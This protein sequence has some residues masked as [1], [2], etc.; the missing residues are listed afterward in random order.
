[1]NIHFIG[2]YEGHGLIKKIHKLHGTIF[3]DFF[4][5]ARR[6]RY[7][8]MCGLYAHKNQNY[9]PTYETIFSSKRPLPNDSTKKSL[10][11]LYVGLN[12]INTCLKVLANNFHVVA[13]SINKRI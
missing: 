12:F 4:V 2:L 7:E 1:M 9:D 11:F 10:V 3:E 6:N 13:V 5:T 8:L